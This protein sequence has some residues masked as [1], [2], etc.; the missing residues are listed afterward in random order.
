METGFAALERAINDH[1]ASQTA[2]AKVIG[3]TPQAV[4][5]VM[6]R[7]STVP[8]TWCL[9][10]ERATQG[11]VTRHQLRPDLYPD[12]PADREVA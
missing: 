12:D 5:E 3:V 9:P 7:K 10:I 11:K 2:A 4:S 8:A 1:F 6:R